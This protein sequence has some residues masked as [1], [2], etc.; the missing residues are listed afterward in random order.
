MPRNIAV[1]LAVICV[2]AGLLALWVSLRHIP[3]SE[4]EIITRIAQS[5]AAQTGGALT[6]C[7]AR[8]SGLE[9]VRLVVFCQQADG[10]TFLYPVDDL[11]RLLDIDPS[12]LESREPQA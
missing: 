11:G 9:Q 8:P 2:L 3:P 4:T 5:Y 1:S 10:V 7:F 12:I 6:D